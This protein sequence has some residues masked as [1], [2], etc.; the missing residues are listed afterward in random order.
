MLSLFICARRTLR[1]HKV[2]GLQ[3]IFTGITALVF[4]FSAVGAYAADD[5]VAVRVGKVTY[6]LSEVQTYWDSIAQMAS[7]MK[8]SLTEEE[9]EQYRDSVIT[10]YVST[11]ILENKY[12]EFGLDKLTADDQAALDEDAK[13]IY[14]A[15]QEEFTQNIAEQYGK[16]KEEAKQFAPTFLDLYG[17]TMDTAREEALL[18]LKEDRILKYVATDIPAPTEA[19]VA[20]YYEEHFVTPSREPTQITSKPLNRMFSTTAV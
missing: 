2:H 11:G 19:E 5:P 4:L 15:K 10:S 1:S 18:T 9:I 13:R 17:Y 16:T 14:T 8:D 6:S 3:K 7:E 12:V 20:A